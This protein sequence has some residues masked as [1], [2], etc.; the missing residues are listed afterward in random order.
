[1]SRTLTVAMVCSI[2]IVAWACSA[3][4]TPSGL[5]TRGMTPVAVRLDMRE[6]SEPIHLGAEVNSSSRELRPALSPDGL[7]LYFGSDRPGGNGGLDLWVA[8]RDCVECPWEAAVNLGAMLNTA[9]NEGTPAFSTDGR[10]LFF[11]SDRAGGYGG[12]DIYVAHR[13]DPSDNRGWEAP[14]NLG[15]DVNT[16]RLEFGSGFQQNESGSYGAL[17]FSRGDADASDI[18]VAEL[19]RT[20]NSVMTGAPASLVEELSAVG[21]MANSPTLRGDGKELIFWSNR[22]GGLGGPDLWVSTRQTP[23]DAWATP[24]DLG[25]PV[26]SAFAD[27]EPSLSHDGRTLLFS[28]NALRGG[29]G[30]QDIW[31]SRRLIDAR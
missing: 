26:N 27:F 12:D 9:A 15:P 20:E 8:S 16:D 7:S 3:G 21:F 17:Y 29:L 25:P 22:P 4:D 1:M 14:T 13:D 23:H 31:M 28:A 19:E 11:T 2:V 18:Y 6:W 5:R 10:F 24:I 30:R